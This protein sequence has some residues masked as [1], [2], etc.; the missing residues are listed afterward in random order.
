M[1]CILG[2]KSDWRAELRY[3]LRVLPVAGLLLLLLLPFL[4]GAYRAKRQEQRARLS[5]RVYLNSPAD[6]AAL[7]ELGIGPFVARAREYVDASVSGKQLLELRQRGYEVALIVEVDTSGTAPTGWPGVEE[8]E[9]RIFN[10]ERRHPDICRV[11]S[12]GKSAFRKRDIW[13]LQISDNPGQEEDEPS[14]LFT[15]GMHAREPLGMLACLELAE[16]LVDGYGR[17]PFVTDWIRETQIYVVPLVNPDGYDYILRERLPFPWWRKNLADN[18]HDGKF[19]PHVDGVDLNRNFAFNWALGGDGRPSSWFYRGPR[20]FSEPE[21]QALRDLALSIRPVAGISFHSHGEAVLY[22]WTNFPPPVDEVLIRQ[23]AGEMAS[24]A[25]T[26]KGG[27]YEIY[28]LNGRVGQSSCWLY[29]A[30]SCLDFTVEVGDQYFPP[31]DQVPRQVGEA[32]KAAFYLLDRVSGAG[33]SLKVVDSGTREPLVATVQIEELGDGPG[34][35]R[36]TD[37]FFGRYRCLLQ[38]GSYTLLVDAPKHAP[39]RGK[40]TVNSGRQTELTVA[41]EPVEATVSSERE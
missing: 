4:L 13:A 29:G 23:L 14:V 34:A 39:W 2:S 35:K 20:P 24:V 10:L 38:P 33:L 21:V 40:F 22:P 6:T 25:S 26:A 12:I 15:G 27:H 30:L 18:D 31:L 28:P 32:V 11:F 8:I 37:P 7:H 17:K 19:D 36:H 41:L 5:V 3:G 9:Q 1:N 16:R